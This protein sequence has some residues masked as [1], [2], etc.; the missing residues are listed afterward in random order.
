MKIS[1]QKLIILFFCL[2]VFQPTLTAQPPSFGW[3]RTVGSAG[4]NEE[5]VGM[6]LDSNKAVVAAGGFYNTVDFDAGSGTFNLVS[7]GRKDFFITKYTINGNFVWAKSIGGT[8]DDYV[9]A[10]KKDRQGNLYLLGLYQGTVDFDPGPGVFNV[11]AAGGGNTFILK[12]DKDANFL[13]VKT[14]TCRGNTLDIDD[15]GNIFIGGNFGGTTDFDPGPAVFNMTGNLTGVLDMFV[16]KLD[17]L[18]NFSWAKQIRNLTMSQHQEFGLE[19]DP[20]GNVFFAGN[21]TNSMDFDPSAASVP[22]TS[23]GS[24]NTFIL[25]LNTQGDY[26]WAKQFVGAASNKSFGLEVDRQ[27]NVFSTGEFSNTVDF[28]PGP[29]SFLVSAPTP[30]QCAFISKLDGA[31]NFVYAKNFQSGST[32]GQA[33]TIDSS[34]NLY[35]SGYYTNT[36]DFDPGPGIYNIAGSGLFTAKLTPAGDFA[37]AVGYSPTVVGMNFESIY[38]SVL[39]D[40]SNSVYFGGSFSG[41]VD[42]DPGVGSFPVSTSAYGSW[43]AYLH[44]LGPAPCNNGTKRVINAQVCSNYVL[45][46]ITYNSSG[47]YFQLLTNAAS[48]DSIIQLNLTIANIQTNMSQTSCGS[49]VWNGQILNSSGI[50]RDTIH[51]SNGC[52]SVIVLNLTVNNKPLP[53][54]GKD[55]V[56]CVPDTI[57]LSAGTF[58]SYL[59]NNGSTTSSI[60]VTQPGIYWINVTATN[61]CSARDSLTIALSGNCLSCTDSKLIEKIYPIPFNRILTV[62]IKSSICEL[63]VDIYN[64]L[65]QLI[66]KKRRKNFLLLHTSTRFTTETQFLQKE[67]Y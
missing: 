4:N 22:L 44:K 38:S 61:G 9:S 21:F 1:L 36:V 63:S 10:L 37:W 5:V 26:Q 45:N 17:N 51:L 16:M 39:V 25:K 58:A 11:S 32:A 23:G 42:F 53:N 49:L 24:D 7:N 12:M 54:L 56:I 18:G 15:T 47:Q 43:D 14:I 40:Q 27:G 48:C 67:K 8:Q 62:K 13:W 34:N 35:I 28:D 65:G 46:G 33:L 64:V 3:V 30:Q 20:V 31:G 19:T 29:A 50:Y 66:M 6:V 52:D 55:T 59:W 57:P 2:S 60:A 41:T